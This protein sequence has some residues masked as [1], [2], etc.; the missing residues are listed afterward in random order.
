MIFEIDHVK[1]GIGTVS[2]C[3]WNIRDLA[4]HYAGHI[5]VDNLALLR[6][7]MP[8]LWCPLDLQVEKVPIYQRP[9]VICVLEHFRQ[10][11][12]R[13]LSRLVL[14]SEIAPQ[15]RLQGS[16]HGLPIVARIFLS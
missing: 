4:S 15:A 14:S 16:P 1:D 13:P 6:R 11:Y 9:L 2:V 7:V 8:L 5:S 3:V 10:P 12:A